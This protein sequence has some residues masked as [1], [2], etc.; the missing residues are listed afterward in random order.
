M[1][2]ILL[3]V[4]ILSISWIHKS[5]ATFSDEIIRRQTLNIVIGGPYSPPDPGDCP[6][7]CSPP[8]EPSPAPCPEPPPPPPPPPAPAYS[9]PP[10]PRQPSPP[11]P[12]RP[13]PPP[14]RQPSPPRPTRPPPAPDT[15][16][17]E[18]RTAIQVIQRFKRTITSDPLGVTKT[19]NGDRIC[20]DNSV[21]KGF[22]CDTT[23]S[24]NK[25]RVAGVNFNG[26]GLAGR[27]L[28]LKN[29]LDGLKDLV[30]FHANSV[31]FTGDVPFGISRISSL[32]ELDLSNNKLQGEFPKALLTATNLTFLDVRFNKLTGKLPPEVF[33]LDLDVLFLNN[34]EFV[35]SIPENIGRTPV[36]YLTLANNNFQGP[37]P[38]S[39][40]Q[41]SNT[42]LEALLLNNHLSG[43]LPYEIGLLR[44]ANLFDVSVNTLTGPIPQSFRCLEN[45]QFLN[46]SYNQFYGPVPES[47]CLLG[48]LV[49]LTLKSNYFTQVGPEC[50]K[51]ISEKV[52]DVSMN[53][54]LGLPGQRSPTV[55]NA[56]F[57]KQTPCP[58]Q[59][60]MSTLVPCKISSSAVKSRVKRNL[61]DQPRSYAALQ[62]HSP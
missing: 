25:L 36:L 43:C 56:F 8:P 24:D 39:I 42:L 30:V 17:P 21:Y 16:S 31:N 11:R 51:K 6:D 53:C 26:F 44:K 38:K 59:K 46:L 57:L 4:F 61:M 40:G 5:N 55:C 13:P 62:R 49:K 7:D 52:L 28:E 60:L 10:P 37:I 15:L 20:R 27:P 18:L 35:G 1:H 14:P 54:I 32:F 12:T 33:T 58:D 23:I 48:D 47:L 50:R 19:W 45:M 29:F 22:I 3:I 2:L 41:A 34:N 9:P